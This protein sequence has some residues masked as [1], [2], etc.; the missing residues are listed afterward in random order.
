MAIAWIVVVALVS[1]V[2]VLRERSEHVLFRRRARLEAKTWR[3]WSREEQREAEKEAAQRL[4]RIREEKMA[5][6]RRLRDCTPLV[7]QLYMRH[8]SR[9]EARDRRE[10]SGV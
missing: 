10:A 4:E 9:F 6:I 2:A 3:P 7:W 8:A 1:T 5:L